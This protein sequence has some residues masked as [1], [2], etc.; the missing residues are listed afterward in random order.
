[1]KAVVS[2]LI[3]ASSFAVQA[4]PV[5]QAME[6]CRAEQNALKRLLCYDAINTG[7]SAAATV[8]SSVVT[9]EPN[10]PKK[11]S[12]DKQTQATS[13]FGLE[14]RTS[15]DSAAETLH[16]TVSSVKYT[17]HNEL[18]V[19][20]DNGQQWR[21]QGNDYYRIAVGEKHHISRGIMNSFMLGNDDNNRTI[22]IRREQ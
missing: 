20:F 4:I 14:H 22:R 21:Q 17:A 19:T 16:V 12:P 15:T 6:L 8:V 9:S 18:L 1:M 7:Q 3:L 11:T 13:D 2:I 10:K 5:E